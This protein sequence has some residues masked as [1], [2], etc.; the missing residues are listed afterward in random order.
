MIKLEGINENAKEQKN[1][2][3]N[4]SLCN[5]SLI[6]SSYNGKGSLIISI[7]NSLFSVAYFTKL[8]NKKLG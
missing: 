8:F 2:T 3:I 1:K 5:S 6:W 7:F 4:S